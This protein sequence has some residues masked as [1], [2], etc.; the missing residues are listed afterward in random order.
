M[1]EGEVVVAEEESHSP[2]LRPFLAQVAAIAPVKKKDPA[3]A[4]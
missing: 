4:S 1:R 2:A 3:V